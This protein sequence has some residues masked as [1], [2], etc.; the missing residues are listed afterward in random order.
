MK[1]FGY[2]SGIISFLNRVADI[3][4]LNV[5]FIIACLPIITYGPAK[6]ALYACTVKWTKKEDAGFLTFFREFKV[7]FRS[8]FPTGILM[9]VL[10]AVIYLDFM[11]SFLGE[12]TKALRIITVIVAILFFPYREQ[13]FLFSARFECRFADLLRNT[14]IVSLTN[15]VGGIVSALLMAAPLLIWMFSPATFIQLTLVWL[16]GYYSLAAWTSTLLM[17][18][19]HNKIIAEH[20]Q[21]PEDDRQEQ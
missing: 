2:D 8:S 10:T 19:M 1:R 6:A 15:P 20:E 7:N 9:L 4:S 12:C 5:A 14:L 21:P 13:L 17:Q 3:M 18:K 11:L 16:L